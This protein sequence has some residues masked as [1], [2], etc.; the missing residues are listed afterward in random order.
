MA[1]QIFS[2]KFVEFRSNLFDVFSK[3]LFVLPIVASSQTREYTCADY[4]SVVK[5][6]DAAISAQQKESVG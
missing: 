2:D 4:R 5:C 6:K 3:S 1:N